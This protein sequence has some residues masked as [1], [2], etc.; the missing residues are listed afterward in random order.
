VSYYYYVRGLWDKNL[1]IN[2]MGAEAARKLSDTVEEGKLLSWHVQRLST[3]G[4]IAEAEKYLPRLQEIERSAHLPA[5]VFHIFQRTIAS[6]WTARQDLARAQA[7]WQK[8]LDRTEESSIHTYVINR[9]GLASFLYRAGQLDEAR[10]ILRESLRDAI[11]QGYTRAIVSIQSQLAAID[12]DQGNLEGAA[13]ILA[14]SS[15][16]AY[17]YQIRSEIAF[18][19]RRYARLHTMRGDLPA[20]RVAL[21]DAID[22]F[23]RL[24]MR[25]ALA[26]ARAELVRL[27]Q[28]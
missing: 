27:E 26:E 3:Q 18:I 17:Q 16:K 8:S 12:L 5:D 25:S 11:Q 6:Y 20:A 13:E 21:V 28:L 4:N 15:A 9:L 2:R 24:G 19:Q 1:S 7:A 14:E 23:E 22:L 10:Q